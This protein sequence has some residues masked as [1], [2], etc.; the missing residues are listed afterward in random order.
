MFASFGKAS[1]VGFDSGYGDQ[2][3]DAN[4]ALLEL[5]KGLRSNKVGEQCEA[6]VRFPRLFE[7]YPF[8]ILINSA[9]LKLADVFRDGSNFLRMCILRVTQQSNKH[10]DKILNIDEFVRRIFFVIHSN[11]PVARALTLRVLGSIA[12]IISERKSVHHSIHTGLD[13]HDKVEME[14]AI[15]AVSSFAAESKAFANG[16]CNKLADLIQGL[17]TP[18]E[19]KLKLI[20]TFEHMHH[21]AHSAMMVNGVC[22]ELLDLYPVDDFLDVLLTTL[23]KLALASHILIPE[24]ITLLLKFLTNQTSDSVKLVALSNLQQLAERSPHFFTEAHISD[25]SLSGQDLED[26]RLLSSRL[27]V[28]RTLSKWSLFGVNM[29]LTHLEDLYWTLCKHWD[30]SIAARAL[31]LLVKLTNDKQRLQDTLIC[32]ETLLTQCIMEDSHKCHYNLKL[33]LKSMQQ[34][35]EKDSEFTESL[36]GTLS[37]GLSCTTGLKCVDLCHGLISLCEKNPSILLQHEETLQEMFDSTLKSIEEEGAKDLLVALSVPLLLCS[38]KSS[39]GDQF[40]HERVASLCHEYSWLA[41]KISR[42]ATR[43]G[44]HLTASEFFR[45]LSTEVASENYYFWLNSLHEFTSAESA[46]LELPEQARFKDII[47]CLSTSVQLYQK[48]IGCLKAASTPNHP[49]QFQLSFIRLRCDWLQSCSSLVTSL[50][51]SRTCPP[52]AIAPAMAVANGQELL[53]CGHLAAQMQ[54]CY[55]HLQS[56]ASRFSQLYRV[57]F[58]ADPKTL[59][60]IQLMQRQCYLLM[61]TVDLLILN[62]RTYMGSNTYL[63]LQTLSSFEDISNDKTDQDINHKVTKEILTDSK[64]VL[65]STEGQIISHVHTNCILDSCLA[66]LKLPFTFPRYFYQALQTTTIKLALSPSPRTS[67][68]PT[69]ISTETQLVLK[70]EGVIQHGSK[71]GLFRK[72]DQVCL[73]VSASCSAKAAPKSQ[74][75]DHHSKWLISP[76]NDY[77][78]QQVLLSCPTLGLYTITVEASI[79]DEEGRTWQTGPRRTL[80]VKT[81]Q[82]IIS[83]MNQPHVNSL[84]GTSQMMVTTGRLPS[85]A[86]WKTVDVTTEV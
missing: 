19:I 45:L 50:V 48:G 70:I 63:P 16:I 67:G 7:K 29:T 17:S 53:K 10:L 32:S 74:E 12:S 55:N 22:R 73:V 39:S 3:Q 59:E 47:S 52:P 38:K 56:L 25:L 85:T 84:P 83:A 80:P 34:L 33:V 6:I 28:L 68:E 72:V 65:Q 2:E 31:E 81:Y 15:Y 9:F 20:P 44:C 41:F 24:Q 51:T 78:S 18:T 62:N 43:L 42:Q 66:L 40:F 69:L 30:I 36:V 82:D 26:I 23:T 37:T 86:R 49:L 35:C 57:S 76:H 21:D 11:D 77:F 8:P 64:Q 58:D 75:T 4:S 13:S 79:V 27:D 61:H 60:Q 71:P 1:V 5:D 46:L 14:A 54:Q